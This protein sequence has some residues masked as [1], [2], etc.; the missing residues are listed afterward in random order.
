MLEQ[1]PNL[2]FAPMTEGHGVLHGPLLLFLF[3]SVTNF[4]RRVGEVEKWCFLFS[5]HIIQDK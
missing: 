2:G 1:K 5:I 4:H 3:E